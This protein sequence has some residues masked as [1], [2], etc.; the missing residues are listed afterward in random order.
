MTNQNQTSTATMTLP[1]LVDTNKKNLTVLIKNQLKENPELTIAV[2]DS[3]TINI[4]AAQESLNRSLDVSNFAVEFTYKLKGDSTNI[5]LV[6]TEP[7]HENEALNAAAIMSYKKVVK[8]TLPRRTTSLI[9]YLTNNEGYTVTAAVYGDI[10]RLNFN[11][12]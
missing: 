1:S 6:S 9:K 3:A 12:A 10:I 2:Y 4:D 5:E 7:I 11:K 8:D